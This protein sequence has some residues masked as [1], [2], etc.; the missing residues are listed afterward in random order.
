MA[1]LVIAVASLLIAGGSAACGQPTAEPQAAS[2][3]TPAGGFR[4]IAVSCP[5]RGDFTS[6][7]TT[8]YSQFYE[9]YVLGY[10]FADV[11]SGVYVDVGANDPDRG[12]VTKRLYL[13]GWSGVNIEPNPELLAAFARRR[14]RDE[15]VG[16][17]IGDAPGR[18][19]FYRFTGDASGLSTFDPAVARRHRRAGF[20]YDELDVRVTTLTEVLDGSPRVNGAFALLNVDVEGY[21][22]QVLSGLDFKKYPPAV[23][24]VEATAPL[25]EQPTQHLWQDVLLGAGYVF[26]MDDGLNRY[27]VGPAAKA[28]QT[29]F[30]EADFCVRL[31]KASKGINLDGFFDH[32]TR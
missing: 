4:E 30:I 9:D 18:L 31:D 23:V 19:R 22:R 16:V 25:T 10:V 24:M 15:N 26:A 1:R 13:K 17:G 20:R 29:K 8:Y 11:V 12:S 28:L 27:Y 14:S 7:T 5:V 2:A 3:L 21:E 32:P 6:D